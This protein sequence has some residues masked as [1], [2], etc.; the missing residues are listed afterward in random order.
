MF[1][2]LKQKRRKFL[3]DFVASITV[4]STSAMVILGIFAG[5]D[6]GFFTPVW[7]EA[8]ELFFLAIY[9]IMVPAFSLCSL[10]AFPWR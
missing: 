5:I 1:R 6:V 10:L 7:K 4:G 2:S 9:I 3:K 8:M